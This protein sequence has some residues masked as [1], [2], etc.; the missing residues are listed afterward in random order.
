MIE[1]IKHNNHFIYYVILLFINEKIEFRKNEM[2]EC[3]QQK[4][5]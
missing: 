2:D 5:N 4:N 3:L 1:S